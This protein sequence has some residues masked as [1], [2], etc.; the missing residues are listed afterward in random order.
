MEF[1]GLLELI[2][3]EGEWNV[4]ITVQRSGQYDLNHSFEVS[5]PSK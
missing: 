5:I 4:K 1:I 3:Q 2:S